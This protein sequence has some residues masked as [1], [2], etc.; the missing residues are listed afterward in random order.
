MHAQPRQPEQPQPRQPKAGVAS[1]PVV[2]AIM[3]TILY[4]LCTSCKRKVSQP[5]VETIQMPGAVFPM[6]SSFYGSELATGNPDIF[7]GLR[8]FYSGQ[9]DGKDGKLKSQ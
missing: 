2:I 1:P 8:K 9:V 3:R 5:S 4:I 7:P 6:F